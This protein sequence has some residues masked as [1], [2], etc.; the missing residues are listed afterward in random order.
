MVPPRRGR[1]RHGPL[2]A[3]KI[4][5]VGNDAV[6]RTSLIRHLVEGAPAANELIGRVRSVA[7]PLP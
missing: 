5:V 3:A 1:G 4:L 7:A 6:G 2:N